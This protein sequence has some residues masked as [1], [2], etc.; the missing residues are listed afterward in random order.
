MQKK[1]PVRGRDPDSRAPLSR[2]QVLRAAADFAD[3]GGLETLSMRGLGRKLGVEAMSLYNHVANKD[4]L[5]DGMMDLVVGSIELPAPE[6]DWRQAMRRR[7]V[8]ALKAFRRHTWATALI[9]SRMGGGPGRLRY[10]EAVL[11]VL[12]RAGFTTQLAARAFS[13]LDSY[14]YGFCRQSLNISS[15][16]RASGDENAAEAFLRALPAEEYPYLA[17]LAAMQ[18]SR[19][20][21]DEEADFEFGLSLIL[22]GLQGIL[23]AVEHPAR[24]TGGTRLSARRGRSGRGSPN[25]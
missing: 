24:Q 16:E 25:G 21:Y 1:K 18:A 11:R 22:D 20:G 8:S 7:A 6:D 3:E 12:R 15:T 17:E 23:D 9:E 4:D 19:P 2:E 14:I 10:F 13:L 5:L